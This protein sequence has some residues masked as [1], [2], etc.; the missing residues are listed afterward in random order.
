[1]MNFLYDLI[2][3]T[4]LGSLGAIIALAIWNRYNENAE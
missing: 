1:M 4:M 3:L 2:T